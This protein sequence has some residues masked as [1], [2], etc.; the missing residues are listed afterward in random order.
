M[1]NHCQV[2]LL[3]HDAED[4]GKILY[5]S[6]KP[7]TNRARAWVCHRTPSFL[8]RM[9]DRQPSGKVSIRFWQRG[10]GGDRN[11]R[12]VS[13]VHEKIGYVHSNPVRAGLV[14]PAADW[15]WSNYRAWESGI[16]EPIPIDRDTLP[17]LGP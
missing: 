11:L 7:V 13:D 3:P 8:P 10:A 2:L 17:P 5:G 16:D 14:T 4:V 9:H 6:K 15:P 1:P 12:T